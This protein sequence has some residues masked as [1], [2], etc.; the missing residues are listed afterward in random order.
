MQRALMLSRSGLCV[1][2]TAKAD[3]TVV[4]DVATMN[5]PSNYE[6]LDLNEATLNTASTLHLHDMPYD[7]DSFRIID[8]LS[9]CSTCNAALSDPIMPEPLHTRM[10]TWQSHL[11]RC[12][13]DGRCLQAHEEVKLAVKRLAL[14]NPNPGGIAL[15]SNL[16]LIEPIRLRSDDSRM[17]TYM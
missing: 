8:P 5:R 3:M 14:C 2:E 16:L 11:G 9:C 12:G 7:F 4:Q 6:H 17:V 13:S 1:V 10:H 15:P